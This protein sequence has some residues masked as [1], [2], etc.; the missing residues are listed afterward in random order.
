MLSKT[1][2]RE[3]PNGLP[4]MSLLRILPSHHLVHLP[5]FQQCNDGLLRCLL[6]NARS[7]VCKLDCINV[8]IQSHSP[9][10][11]LFTET[12]L[13]SS[14][15]D[16][17]L[18]ASN[19]Y[20]CYRKDRDRRGGGVCIMARPEISLVPVMLPEKLTGLEIVAVDL[21]GLDVKCRVVLV[22]RAPSCDTLAQSEML[23]LVSC[24]KV[25][26]SVGYPTV[27]SGDLNLPHLD[28]PSMTGPNDGIYTPFMELVNELGLV[29][30][31]DVP[32][33]HTNILD[34][35][36]S[37]DAYLVCD[38][39]VEPPLGFANCISKP[40]DHNIVSFKLHCMAANQLNDESILFRDFENTD[41]DGL[42]RYLST[43][44]WSAV[45]VTS[46]DTNTYWKKFM[47]ILNA[48]IELYVPVRRKKMLS[49]RVGCLYPYFIRQ[50]LRK[51]KAAWRKFRRFHTQKLYDKYVQIDV[52][53]K[54]AIYK[55]DT[56]KERKLVESGNVGQFYKYVNNKIIS[57]TGIGIVKNNTGD[58]LH[59]DNDK[60]ECFNSFFSSVFTPDNN[61]IPSIEAKALPNSIVDVTFAYE[62]VVKAIHSIKAKKSAGPDG[63][64]SSFLKGLAASISFPL[65]LI[66]SQSFQ[67]G[68]LP[69]V[70]K[71]AV[72]TPVHKKGLVCDVNNYRP[73]SLT[74]VCCKLMESIIK[75]QVLDYFLSKSIISKHQH[76]FLSRH[77]T[78]SQMLE[79]INDWTLSIH[80]C[81]SVDVIYVDFS[82]AFD[83]VCHSKLLYKLESYGIGGKLIDWIGAYLSGR[84]QMVRIGNSFSSVVNVTSGVP[85]GSVLGPL[86]FLIYINDL[87]NIFGDSLSVKLFADDVKIYAELNSS[88]SSEKLQDGLN[89]LY[90]WSQ[91]WQLNVSLNKCFVLH[92]GNV[93]PE[94]C[95]HIGGVP[96]KHLSQAVDLGVIVDSKLRFDKHV[97][98]VVHKAHQRAA[99]IR[100]CFKTRDPQV[101]F[102]AFT[103]YVRPLLEYCSSVWNPSYHCD[104]DKIESVQRRFTKYLKDAKDCSYTHRLRLLNA[105][106]LEL[107]R[108][109]ADLVLV[110]SMFHKL[111]ALEISSF[112]VKSGVITR[113][114]QWKLSRQFCRINCR[115]HFFSNRCIDVWNSLGTENVCSTSVAVFKRLL[116]RC[117]F[118]KFLRVV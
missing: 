100:R 51:R 11:I 27:L 114:H 38:W 96:L 88:D 106:S 43:I 86:L 71:T 39:A 18:T 57:K 13:D 1:E 103:V 41:F 93:N 56:E 10:L 23:D 94:H 44:D 67:T 35:I 26:S 82:K 45:L 115:A 2:P 34:I 101:L 117:D 79:C 91:E 55:F 60:A 105:E 112:F 104:I 36:L 95:Y 32:T 90:N 42:N 98:H 3:G 92:V 7:I 66:F 78:Q 4:S 31:V 15:P 108:L 12:W 19:N 50:M 97:A 25:L 30:F 74:S 110:Y 70:W 20:M 109:K 61:K 64:S 24:L 8:I 58:M 16:S 53:C 85:Q 73:I 84:T 48:G 111:S 17:M 72:V 9:D 29:Q 89:K 28:W 113:G 40:S 5:L 83:S 76:G 81:Y 99:L 69:E 37:N 22:Y 6:C 102:K 118:S 21:L 33:R 49:R 14:I 59:A 46:Y 47:E 52:K 107:R 87:C 54:D 63:L 77:S 65:M 116:N 68:Q 80:N 62:D 75:K